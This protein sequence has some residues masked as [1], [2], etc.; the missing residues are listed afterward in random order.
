M[1][2]CMYM[3]LLYYFLFLLFF[4]I[5]FIFFFF[6]FFFFF[7]YYNFIFFFFFFFQA[8]DGIRDLYVTGVQTCAL[9]ISATVCSNPLIYFTADF[10]LFFIFLER[11]NFPFLK[12]V[13]EM[14][15]AKRLIRMSRSYP[16]RKSTRLNSSHVEISYAVFCLKKKIKSIIQ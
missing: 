3:I 10:T 7:F 15:L 14:K 8:E 1:F 13:A 5:S 12:T 6:L 11:D 4:L 2:I 16:D 9:P